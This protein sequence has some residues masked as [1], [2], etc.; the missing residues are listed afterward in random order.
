[1]YAMRNIRPVPFPWRFLTCIA[2]LLGLSPTP[3][4]ESPW[5]V[6]RLEPDAAWQLNLPEGQAF[7]ASALALTRDGILLTV[8]DRSPAIYRI[9][10]PEGP[11][12]ADLV[13]DPGAFPADQLRRVAGTPSGRYDCEGLALDPHGRLYLCEES[14]RWI[15]RWDPDR[16]RVERLEIDW[17]PVRQ[18]FS[19][20]DVNASFEGVAVGNDRLYVA[21]ERQQGRIIEVNL[22]SLEVLGSFEVRT[23]HRRPWD[24]HYS[25]L[26]WHGGRL[27]VLCRESRAVLQ[28][29]PQQRAVEA[30]YDFS[31][32]ERNPE[33]RYQ[34]LVP[35]VGI[36]EG[37]AVDDR[38]IWLVTDN[39]HLPRERYPD[40]RRPTLFRC[41]RPSF[42]ACLSPS[43]D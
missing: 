35:L 15:L 7:E 16:R 22:E 12:A 43:P 9:A 5:P 4:A 11:G 38:H 33:W 20:W 13:R 14:Q 21:N 27:Y 26:S 25:D 40:D 3:A 28:V 42:R 19:P 2:S 6:H 18:F 23:H 29:D 30:E 10:L 24:T 36:M 1:V 34:V 32:I 8:S 39:N 41:P 17:S 31:S 37:L